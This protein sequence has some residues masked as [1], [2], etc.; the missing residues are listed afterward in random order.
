MAT[1]QLINTGFISTSMGQM[2]LGSGLV[3]AA[4]MTHLLAA[5]PELCNTAVAG[6][7]AVAGLHSASSRMLHRTSPL[8]EFVL[9]PLFLPN[10]IAK[11]CTE[12]YSRS[13]CLKKQSCLVMCEE[14]NHIDDH[15]NNG[16]LITSSLVIIEEVEDLTPLSGLNPVYFLIPGH[17]GNETDLRGI[18]GSTSEVHDADIDDDSLVVNSIGEKLDTQAQL[19]LEAVLEVVEEDVD[20]LSSLMS[21]SMS[22]HGGTSEELQFLTAPHLVRRNWWRDLFPRGEEYIL[23][24]ERTEL[25]D[26]NKKIRNMLTGTLISHAVNAALAHFALTALWSSFSWANFIL[27]EVAE[28]DGPWAVALDRSKQAGRILARLILSN[29]FC[30]IESEE[31]NEKSAGKSISRDL[32]SDKAE[33]IVVVKGDSFTWDDCAFENIRRG[34]PVTLIGYSM[35]ARVI[36]HCLQ[37]LDACCSVVG[38]GIVE[39]VVLMGAPVGTEYSGWSACRRVVSGRLINCYSRK[40]WF[41]A[42]MYRSNMYEPTVAGL[43]PFSLIRSNKFGV[44]AAGYCYMAPHTVDAGT[45]SLPTDHIVEVTQKIHSWAEDIECVDVSGIIK[46]HAD[47]PN[48]LHA[49]LEMINIEPPTLEP[50]V[51]C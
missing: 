7:S 38:R 45:E 30:Q 8:K 25:A 47:Y 19:A 24:W 13:C 20:K 44:E 2:L 27:D 51:R 4:A 37:E 29:K 18:F 5:M 42:L 41:L 22:G 31:V 46:S 17:V 50:S 11:T 34:R 6:A 33:G 40:D 21:N 9:S 48:Q 35:G 3:D 28:L 14:D 23:Q 32:H 36:Y 26:L 16:E 10:V 39:N 12:D 49:I 1:Q 43:H 15:E